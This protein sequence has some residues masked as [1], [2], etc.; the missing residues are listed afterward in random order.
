MTNESS[1]LSS[2]IDNFVAGMANSAEIWGLPKVAGQIFAYLQTQVE[3]VS[4]NKIVDDLVISKGNVSV[5]IRKLEELGAVKKIWVKGDRR[6]YYQAEMNTFNFTHTLI[7]NN[8][9]AD[10]NNTLLTLDN[11]IN[12]L[13]Q[14]LK[15]CAREELDKARNFMQE[16][17]NLKQFYIFLKECSEEGKKLNAGKININQLRGI[18]SY[19]KQQ[20]KS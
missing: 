18:W 11:S 7:K 3:P 17:Q 19:I 20:L 13:Q 10:I 14:N 9:L 8:Y 15:N 6:D 4:L 1:A 2:V 16:L 5:N 12:A